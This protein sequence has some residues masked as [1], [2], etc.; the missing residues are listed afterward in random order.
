MS[1]A[2]IA[3]DREVDPNIWNY[4]PDVPIPQGGI[5]RH[6]WNPV[7]V[8]KGILMSWFGLYVRGLALALITVLWLTVLPTM[9]TIGAGGWH[10][11]I[12][13]FVVNLTLMLAWAGSLHLYLYTFA[14]QGK[15][16]EFE[17][18][19]MKKGAQFTFGDQV[20]DNMFWT[21]AWS[22][23][24]W[25]AYECGLLWALSQNLI[26]ANSWD[27]GPIWLVLLFVLIP[28]VDSSHFYITHRFLHWRG[29]YTHIHSVHHRNVN[30]GP[31]S[32]VSMHPVES[33]IFFSPLLIHIF[34]PSHPIHIVFHITWLSIGPATTHCG[35]HA[36]SFGGK[37]YPYLGD[38]FHNLHHRFFECNYGNREVPLDKIGGTFHDGSRTA[39]VRI[40]ERAKAARRT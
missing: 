20:Y 3:P 32:G 28:F 17:V 1:D 31:W 36:L 18:K 29:V 35:F 33:A 38:F 25:T 19:S 40:N 8:V 23:P 16:L 9:E 22:V 39:S 4:H 27:Q 13:I 10:W 24:I 21:L 12:Q 7:A 2:E 30:T 5:F 14:K 11:I 6:W 26:P 34:L 15:F 37:R